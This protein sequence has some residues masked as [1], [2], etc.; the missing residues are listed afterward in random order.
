VR[1][2]SREIIQGRNLLVLDGGILCD[3]THS[4]SFNVTGIV[5]FTIKKISLLRKIT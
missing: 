2:I 4:S 5:M 3:M 1:S